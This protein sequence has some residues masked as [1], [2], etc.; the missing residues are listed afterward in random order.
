MQALTSTPPAKC[1]ID[2]IRPFRPVHPIGCA[3]PRGAFARGL[4]LVGIGWVAVGLSGLAGCSLIGA[5]AYKMSGPT[6][7]PAAYVPAKRPTLVLV[8]KSDNPGEVPLESEQIAQHIS[9]ALR[10]HD[11]APLVDGSPLASLRSRDPQRYR[12]LSTAEAGRLTGAAQVLYVDLTE[13]TINDAMATELV[14][15]R[16]SARVRVIDAATGK[17][18]W[19][20]DT[21]QGVPI[22]VDA[23]YGQSGA[24][25]TASP[26]REKMCQALADKIARLFYKYRS[27]QVDAGSPPP[28]DLTQ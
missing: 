7:I 22:S 8:E 10:D 20:L 9:A 4:R 1:R 3:A 24:N 18:L 5:V 11:V 13:F 12:R 17:T 6:D 28:G 25:Q 14:G 15:G 21:T 27:D 26:L 16:V 23:P 2:P 19:P